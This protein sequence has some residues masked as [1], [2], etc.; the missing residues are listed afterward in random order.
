MENL[1]TKHAPK[2]VLRSSLKDKKGGGSKTEIR[3]EIWGIIIEA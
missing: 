1:K 2:L 3:W